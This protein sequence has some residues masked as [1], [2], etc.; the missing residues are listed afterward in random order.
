MKVPSQIEDLYTG[1]KYYSRSMD[2]TS[3][4]YKY[5]AE[6]DIFYWMDHCWT[7]KGQWVLRDEYPSFEIVEIGE[8]RA[9]EISKGKLFTAPHF[10]K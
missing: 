3:H 2:D 9:Q 1:F 7:G 5:N 8:D 4:L 10:D 6:K